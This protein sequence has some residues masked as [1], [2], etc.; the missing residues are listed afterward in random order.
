[1]H[2]AAGF[3]P[4]GGGFSVFFHRKAADMGGLFVVVWVGSSLFL[5]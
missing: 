3:Y 5:L 2:R 4:P 1:V